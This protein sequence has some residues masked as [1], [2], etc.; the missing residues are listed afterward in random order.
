MSLREDLEI[1]ARGVVKDTYIVSSPFP[2]EERFGITSQLRRASLSILLNIREG[3]SRYSVSKSKKELIYFL[4]VSYGSSEEVQELLKLC[5]DFRYG[6]C[7]RNN[8]ILDRTIII[9]KLLRTLIKKLSD[10]N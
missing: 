8:D 7:D 5:I 2:V 1:R 4:N 9:S 6:N 10:Y 3:Y